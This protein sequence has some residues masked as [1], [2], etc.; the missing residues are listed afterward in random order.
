MK[1]RIKK[2]IRF[3]FWVDIVGLG[4]SILLILT[5]LYFAADF[6]EH[7]QNLWS[8][9]AIE[10]LGVWLSVRIIDYLIERHKNFKDTRLQQLR[11]LGYFDDTANIVLSY[12]KVHQSD[13]DKLDREIIYFDKRWNKRKQQFYRD[14]IEQIDELRLSMPEIIESCKQVK[15][16][17]DINLNNKNTEIKENLKG[18]LIIY[19]ERLETLR[20]NIWEESHPDD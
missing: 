8:N 10:L 18:Q 4:F 13:I 17:Y 12:N 9:L 16:S 2:Y 6:S 15:M 20:E 11:N 1:V 3:W 5:Y 19:R 14:E 7:I